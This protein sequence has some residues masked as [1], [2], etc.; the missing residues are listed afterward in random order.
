[1][2]AGA[3]FSLAFEEESGNFLRR[4]GRP[5]CAEKSVALTLHL[6]EPVT[7]LRRAILCI[8]ACCTLLLASG[9]LRAQDQP[10]ITQ[11]DVQ[12][13]R[14]VEEA[15]V[16]FKLKTR[17]GDP[18]S[19]ELV[20]EDIKALFG[21]GYFEDIV[22]R[23]DIFE[24]GLKLTF[25]LQEKPSIQ[26]IKI[27]G[28]RKLDL[29]KIK[30]KLDL[31]EGA[32]VPPGGLAKNAE[33]VRLFYE[34]EGYF[35]AKV[36]GREERISAQEVAVSFSI[37][38]GEHFSIGEIKILGNQALKEREIKKKLQTDE[39]YLW[40]FGGTLKREELRRD[41]DRIRAYYLDN[42]FLDIVV[43]E[44]EIKVD[45][46]KKRL[47]ILI[48]VQEGP[49]YR[50]QGLSIKGA[51]LFPEAE[52]RT[53][54][55]SED[56]GIFSREKLQSD[57]VALTDHYSDRGY[58]FADVNP[59]ADIR[60]E[61][62][63]VRVALE[64]TEGR[65]AFINRI[66]IVGN[67]RTRDKVIRRSLGLVEGDVFRS[68]GVQQARRSLDG[69]GYFE[70]VKV[71]T[72]R[73]AEPDKVDLTI[74]LREKATGA[75][76][77]GGGFSSSDGV[78]GAVSISQNNLF[79]LGKRGSISG[80]VGQFANRFSAV[81]TDPNFWDSDFLVEPRLYNTTTNYSNLLYNTS[82]LGG[83][84]TVGH[85]LPL[86]THGSVT[87]TLERVK[88]SDLDADAPF[89]IQRQAQE[90]GGSAD[91]SSLTAAILRDTRDSFSEPTRGYRV[92]AA[93]QYAGGFLGADANFTKMS[94]EGDQYHPI[95][96]KLIG[97]LRGSLMYGDSFGETP[98]LPVQERFY[99]GGTNTV[100][101]FQ[102]ML[103]SPRDPTTNNYQGGNKAYYLNSELL[104]P[105]LD[106][107]RMRGVVFFDMGNS[108]DERDG[109]G[110]LFS[111][112]PRMGAGLGIRFISPIGAI[113]LEYGFN[114]DRQPGE[115][116]AVLH[117]TAGTTF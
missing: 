95:W 90:S 45:A 14:K 58:L 37:E 13:A 4:L 55:K 102:S 80:Q 18:Y 9:P 76:T 50:I 101:G 115:R 106:Q 7:R 44:P 30:G 93:Y 74:D 27:T 10:L 113:R 56:G 63:V 54:M 94:L 49:Q 97:H 35:Q 68:S 6:R 67:A 23:A 82:T 2:S 108:L 84:M 53:L 107:M 41:L 85:A 77:L 40:F 104:F 66:E 42:G 60:R 21:L 89:L 114:L 52:L 100:R 34:E 15:T 33:K 62:R 19:P 12:G 26:S 1:M 69:L 38:E 92:R 8:A 81:Y 96:A 48:K 75:F 112:K 72:R 86:G 39:L 99:L 83:S 70:E 43:E 103:I 28:N 46:P 47:Q 91:T 57:V 3:N 117:F 17:V 110:E 111:Q 65:Q 71:D 16:R 32:I 87:Y 36:E 22:V 25:A 64:I 109:M 24:G 20:R 61:E 78:I 5:Q 73:T 116:L 79:G 29:D 51:T 11:I 31:V 59:V 105:L 88:L 98:V